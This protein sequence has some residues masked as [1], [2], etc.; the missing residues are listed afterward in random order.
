M[1]N[2]FMKRQLQLQQFLITGT[3]ISARKGK[4][5]VTK[6]KDQERSKGESKVQLKCKQVGS[7]HRSLA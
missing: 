5:S 2:Q 4:L 3:Q 7:K 6:S 1:C